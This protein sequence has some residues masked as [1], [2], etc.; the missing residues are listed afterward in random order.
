MGKPEPKR[1]RVPMFV[2]ALGII[3]SLRGVTSKDCG[4][5]TAQGKP[6]NF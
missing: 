6:P 3:G 5:V 2:I 4:V 1:Q